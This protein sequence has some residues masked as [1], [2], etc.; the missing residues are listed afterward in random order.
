MAAEHWSPWTEFETIKRELNHIFDLS[1]PSPFGAG[2]D[3]SWQPRLDVYETDAAYVVEADLPGMR[4]E[5]IIVRLEDTKLVITGERQSTH[6]E[7]SNSYTHV[8]RTFGPFQ[9]TFTLPTAV[10]MDEV[11]ATYTNGVLTVTVPKADS[12]RPRQITVQ[13]A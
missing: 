5:G 2:H 6:P 1:I 10:Q 9:R 3:A 13:A 12:A 4:I 11:H 8:E 7:T